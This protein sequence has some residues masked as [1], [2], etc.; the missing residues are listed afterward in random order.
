MSK[1][2]SFKLSKVGLLSLCVAAASSAIAQDNSEDAIKEEVV[3]TGYRGSLL[4]STNAKRNSVG[5]SDEVFAD[6]IG[7][8]PSQNLAESLS[9]IPGVKISREVTGEGQ[10][11]TVRGLGSSFTKVVMNGNSIA[12]AS[13]GSMGSG[14]RGRHVDLDMFPPE[15][16]SSLAVNK[17]T[18][19]D[20]VEGGV[21][22]YVNM[23]TLRASD[24][25]EGANFRFGVEG[26]Y[27]EMSGST[28]PRLSFLGGYSDDTWGVMGGVVIRNSETR[29]D[30]WETI[31][32]YQA[33][34]AVEWVDVNTRDCVAGST[35]PNTFHFATYA[36]PDYAAAN[37][38]TAGDALNINT[39]SGLS[40]TQLDNFTLP[41][42]G[43]PMYTFGD[44]DTTSAIFAVEF[45][46]SDDVSFNLDMLYSQAD[47]NFLRNEFNAIY[48]RNYLQFGLEWLPENITLGQDDVISSGTFWNHRAW[49]GSRLYD[50]EL[51]YLAIMPSMSWN[52]SDV[53]RMDASISR[54]ESDF[55]RDEPYVFAY[56]PAGRAYFDYNAKFPI[57][58]TDVP[59]D[60]VTPGWTYEA[61][62]SPIM[63]SE[64][65]AGAFRFQRGARDTATDS[66]NLD[67]SFGEDADVNG[68]K[69]GL[70][71][72]KIES[73]MT[74]YSGAGFGDIV[75]GSIL[76]TNIT[77]VLVDSPIQD[78]GSSISGY[79]GVDGIISFDW[80]ALKEDVGYN[81]FNPLGSG[82]GDQFGQTVGDISEEITAFYIEAN[83]ENDIAGH[84]LRTNIGVRLVD[85]EQTV[86]V[87]DD[88]GN[89]PNV[90]ETASTTADYTRVLPSLSA[91][92]DASDSIKLRASAS[93][94]FTRANPS[95]MFP[96]TAWN[97]SGI[98]EVQAGNPF[99]APFESTNFDIG[100][101]WYFDEDDLGY[102]GFTYYEKDI[103]GFTKQ[104]F[105]QVQYLE[106]A[107]YGVDLSDPSPTQQDALSACGG[108]SDEDCVTNVVTDVNIDGVTKLYG[109]ELIWVQPLDIV[110]EGL[111][112]NA[113]MNKIDQNPSDE[114]GEIFGL[115]DS[116]NFTAYY[117]ND[118][119]Q[120]RVTYT[121]TDE[122]EAGGGWSPVMAPSR[123]QVDFSAS[124]NLPV[125]E[126]YNLT[127]T[128]DAYNLTN[129]PLHT[130]FES[131]G[132]TFNIY[133]PGA[134]YTFGIRGSF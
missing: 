54:T 35:S 87:A 94:S 100:G 84:S 52:I 121:K 113:S 104:D 82:T 33:G 16:F 15:L 77:S 106:L 40:D 134:T 127:L 61:G 59:I 58:E 75:T 70:A 20:Q 48:R 72:D 18:T 23:R 7:K 51:D 37:G 102:V 49:V 117:E 60:E 41:Y 90:V 43:R 92:F 24:L 46:A 112:F 129:E 19:S 69:F 74:G 42:I 50:E 118:A 96:T 11:I 108:P 1:A 107:N 119:F 114:D 57:F 55:S 93:R 101:E 29:V 34:C 79:R 71:F 25:G 6:D 116:F 125:L 97:G 32:N 131:D 14:A 78:F 26:A 10:Q 120:T 80:A 67:F 88:D 76:E 105:V 13:D 17:T 47:R 109:M 128:F 21:S 5:F 28:S 122:G 64:V 36:T 83:T 85:T 38:L 66:F 115:A 73:D 126:D 133:Y 53:F 44:R 86:A 91:V 99:L 56:G 111:G 27:N 2:R 65:S 9:R 30:G 81:S 4:T 12:V 95:S 123:T 110:V 31:G 62:P 68:I 45:N 103:T 124:Y 39:V 3:V 63:G 8:M 130:V 98:D 89:T 22:G 132:N